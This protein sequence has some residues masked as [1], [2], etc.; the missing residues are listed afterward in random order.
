M[1]EYIMTTETDMDGVDCY[2]RKGEL[3]RCKECQSHRNRTNMCDEWHCH[4]GPFGYCH[5][6]KR[7]GTERTERDTGK[8]V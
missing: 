6:G 8:G 7:Y 5:R 3:V 4:T 2:I 1:K